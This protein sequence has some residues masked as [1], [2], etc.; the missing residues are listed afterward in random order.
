MPFLLGV[1]KR[2]WVKFICLACFLSIICFSYLLCVNI[3]CFVNSL[4]PFLRSEEI[5]CF[6]RILTTWACGEW[7]KSTKGLFYKF[8]KFL[9]HFFLSF[10]TLYP[11]ANIIKLIFLIS[12]LAEDR[13]RC[14]CKRINKKKEK[15][16]SLLK[17]FYFVTQSPPPPP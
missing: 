9:S 15:G 16:A 5:G 17:W 2:T 4:N 3:F 8:L 6:I 12:S 11:N 7:L 10:S 13:G 14:R 1:Q